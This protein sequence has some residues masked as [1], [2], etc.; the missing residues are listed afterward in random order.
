MG[1]LPAGA[2][3]QGEHDYALWEKR[4]DALMLLL[5]DRERNLMRVDE[6]RRNI[7]AIGPDAYDR[8]GYYERWITSIA[9]TLLQRG[10]ITADELGRKLAEIEA[11]ENRA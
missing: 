4:V 10:V 2:V 1:G 8:M 11:R 9:S 5:S 3:E 7:E 6:L